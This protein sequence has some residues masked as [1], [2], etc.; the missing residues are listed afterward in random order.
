MTQSVRLGQSL[1]VEVD[2]IHEHRAFT[3]DSGFA[4][5]NREE[6]RK[7]DGL[8]AAHRA[9]PS[10][11]NYLLSAAPDNTPLVLT[12]PGPSVAA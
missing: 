9:T 5:A 1:E 10:L 4:A 12:R 2:A 8:A 11:S 6:H 3:I 7:G